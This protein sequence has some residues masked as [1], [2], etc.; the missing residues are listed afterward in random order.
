MGSALHSWSCRHEAPCLVGRPLRRHTSQRHRRPPAHLRALHLG[1]RLPGRPHHRHCNR[2]AH[3]R[4]SRNS[5]CPR[6]GRYQSPSP[7]PNHS[8]PSRCNCR[9]RNGRRGSGSCRGSGSGCSSGSRCSSCDSAS[10]TCRPRT[11]DNH[12]CRNRNR[13]KGRNTDLSGSDKDDYSAQAAT[14]ANLLAGVA[15]AAACAAASSA[16]VGSSAP[17]GTA[18]AGRR[19]TAHTAPAASRA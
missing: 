15:T 2:G 7:P 5:N 16:A 12:C 14:T 4:R 13:N 19:G 3:R 9:S 8:R 18:A 1:G 17:G 10:C 6:L 11:R